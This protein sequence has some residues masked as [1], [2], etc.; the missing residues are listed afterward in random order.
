MANTVNEG[1]PLIAAAQAQKHV[2]HNEALV[3]IDE[4]IS[5]W[6]RVNW[7]YPTIAGGVLTVASS[8]VVPS[9]ETGTTDDITSIAGGADGTIVTIIGS[10]GKTLNVIDG[11]NIKIAGTSRVLNNF[12]D[13]LTLIRRDTDWLEIGFANNG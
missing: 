7:T 2:T 9:P 1:W 13:T 3:E 12:D 4:R 5:T 10:F 11:G 8:A 6:L